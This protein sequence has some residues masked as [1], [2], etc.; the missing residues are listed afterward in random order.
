MQLR[1]DLRIHDSDGPGPREADFLGRVS[2]V[3]D[4]VFPG[5]GELFEERP[6]LGRKIP[7]FFGGELDAL[8]VHEA[9]FA[10]L[11]PTHLLS[12]RL[13]EHLLL[14][15][16]VGILLQNELD[17]PKVEIALDLK[18]VPELAEVVSKRN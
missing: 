5:K 17:A 18:C 13:E 11:G 2:L 15:L 6:D 16:A 8:W 7:G 1:P 14:S 4:L 3:Q 12:V 10:F 9:D